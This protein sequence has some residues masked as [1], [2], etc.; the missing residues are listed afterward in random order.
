V[1]MIVNC[2]TLYNGGIAML[3]KPRRGWWVL[4]GGKV[5]AD[6]L[7]PEAAKREMYEE[8]GLIVTD[9]QLRGIYWL[10]IEGS[11]HAVTRRMIAQFSAKHA[12]GA[13]LEQCKEGQL[14]VIPHEHV[15][16]LSMDPGD[17]LMLEQTW[18]SVMRQDSAIAYGKFKY[19]SD[20]T[21]SDWSI[22]PYSF[23]D[24]L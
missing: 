20:L 18:N 23:I 13:L 2:F 1:Q 6:E 8:A 3:R 19:R 10:F 12:E 16:T 5:E 21:L 4:P 15:E 14:G 24:T 17:K 11:D 7:W 22:A 9:V